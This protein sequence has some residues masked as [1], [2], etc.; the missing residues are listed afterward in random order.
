MDAVRELQREILASGRLGEAEFESLER[1][2]TGH[3]LAA[4]M[5]FGEY[6]LGVA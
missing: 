1:W 4:D 2:L 6:L 5:R 3:I